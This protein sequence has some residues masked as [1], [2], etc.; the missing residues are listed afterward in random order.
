MISRKNGSP[1]GFLLVAMTLL[2][3]TAL[4]SGTFAATTCDVASMQAAAPKDTTITSAAMVQDPVPHCKVEGYSITTNPGPNKVSFGVQL[5][6]KSKWNG[7]F[8]FIGVGGNGGGSVPS[9]ENFAPRVAAGWA[10]AGTDKGHPGVDALD[11]SFAADPVK[12][13]DNA[14]RGAHVSTV[15]AQALTKAYYG[16][17]KFYRYHTGCSGGGDMGMQALKNHPE[18]YDGILLGWVGGPYPDPKKDGPIRNYNTVLREVLREPG[19]WISPA[20]RKFVD[21]KVVEACDAADGAKDGLIQDTRQCKFDFSVLK[22]KSGD[23]PDCLTQPEVTTLN[24]L[25]RDTAFPIT[26]ISSWAYLGNVPPPWTPET[27]GIS[28]NIYAFMNNWARTYLKQPDRD[29]IKNPLTEQEIETMV[30][31][32]LKAGSGLDGWFNIEPYEKDMHKAIFYVGI[33]DPAFPHVGM[34]N[35][36]NVLTKKIGAERVQSF[37]RL[38]QVPGWGHCGGGSGPTDG[39]DVMLDALTKWVEKGTPPQALVMHRGADRVQTLFPSI[40]SVAGQAEAGAR[41]PVAASMPSRD[42]LV[43]Q[44]PMLAVFDKS[45]AEASDAVYEAKNWSCKPSP[46][47]K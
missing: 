2:A 20:K 1:S 46:Y 37:A 3:T 8:Y 16:V 28:G 42:F 12:A 15:A 35:Y 4:S 43:C 10:T 18:D 11:W 47:V 21:A 23:G 30:H 7:R 6:D 34:E 31:E 41:V 29:V 39:T 36:F 33:G 32:Q 38:Y 14:H 19:A 24:H 45:K 17:D 25:A 26:N 22:C 40:R 13:L 27:P 5:P 9:D 44:Y